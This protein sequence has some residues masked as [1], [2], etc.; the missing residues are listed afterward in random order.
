MIDN[1]HVILFSSA[2][3]FGL[4]SSLHCIGM[5]G[6][7]FINV[8]NNSTHVFL[9]QL[10]RLCSYL[11]IGL[12]VYFLAGSLFKYFTI[13]IQKYTL[14]I[15]AF[16]YFFVG[17]KLWKGRGEIKNGKMAKLYGVTFGKIT[18]YRERKVFPF[19]LGLCSALLPCGVF[20]TFLLGVVP[21][22]SPVLVIGFLGSF[23]IGTMPILVGI[24]YFL[25]N[26]LKKIRPQNLL[27]PTYLLMSL[28]LVY[29]RFSI[30]ESSAYCH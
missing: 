12:I 24:K 10:G 23:W 14:V 27:G 25:S 26:L 16:I 15:L 2:F 20:H 7:L 29:L 21:L 8:K 17:L 11:V 22:E 6:P 13:E 4:I 19:L 30:I 9:Y 18:R 1:A 3:L 5:C 28:Y